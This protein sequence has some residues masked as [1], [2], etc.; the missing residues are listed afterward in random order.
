MKNTVYIG[1]GVIK[2]SINLEEQNIKTDKI[3]IGKSILF[4]IRSYSVL[5][6]IPR[7]EAIFS[8]PSSLLVI[9]VYKINDWL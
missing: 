3:T 6:N 9:Y 4:Q 7:F 1:C 5:G 2:P 8:L